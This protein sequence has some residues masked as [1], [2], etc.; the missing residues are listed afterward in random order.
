MGLMVTDAEEDSC[1]YCSSV[2]LA[3]LAIKLTE[4]VRMLRVKRKHLHASAKEKAVV[5]QA[6][7]ST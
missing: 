1:H 2:T 6:R 7:V 3:I 5:S 4:P